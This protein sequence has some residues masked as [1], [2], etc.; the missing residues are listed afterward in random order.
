MTG[1]GK[2]YSVTHTMIFLYKRC[3]SAIR[4][5]FTNPVTNT[6]AKKNHNCVYW[7]SKASLIVIST[8]DPTC[9]YIIYIEQD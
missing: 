2:R 3:C 6:T 5:V 7:G 4:P 9:V 1:S 8:T